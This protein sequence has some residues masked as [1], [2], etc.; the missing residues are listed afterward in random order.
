MTPGTQQTVTIAGDE[1]LAEF[2]QG[3]T[4]PAALAT[5]EQAG[6]RLLVQLPPGIG[7]TRWMERVILHVPPAGAFDLVVVLVPRW[8]ILGE[9]LD[10][11]PPDVRRVVLR[12]RPRKRCGDLD[13]EWLR[14]EQSG[15]GAL[16][17]EL[18]CASCPRRRSCGWP[19]QYGNSLRGVQLILA[20]QQHLI[21]NPSFVRFV[22]RQTKAA[23]ALVLVD[24]SDLLIRP[25]ERTIRRDDLDRFITV[26]ALL[27]GDAGDAS[28]ARARW[29]HMCK[30]AAAATTDDLR[31][32]GWRFP[33][34][35]TRWAVE[36]QRRGCDR[37]GEDFRFLGYD[38]HHFSRSDPSSRERLAGGDLRFAVLRSLGQNF[39]I[40]SGS[41]APGLARYRLDPDHT[42]P[43][44]AS[45]FAGH[46]FE[47]PGTRWYNLASMEGAARFFPGNAARI[48]DFFAALVA[49]NIRQG[50]RTLLVSRKKFI[51][52]CKAELRRR[53]GAMG[54][55]AVRVVTGDWRRHD[56]QDP[57]T[58][59]L[60]NFGVAGLNR[61]EHFEAAYC[62]NSYY[63]SADVV[64]D[65]TQEMEPSTARY[66][67]MIRSG[68]DPPRRRVQ[69]ALP[70]AR[71]PIT[72]FIAQAVLEQ[73]ESDVVV[74]A[75]G[76]VR[77]FT[78]P[79]EIITFHAGALP[80]ILYSWQFRRLAEARAF[81]GLQTAFQGGQASRR[82]RAR[83]LRAA[84]RTL[85]AIAQE[86]GVSLSTVQRDLRE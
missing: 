9:L 39:I 34:I 12:P 27:L 21:L 71:E 72:Q 11:L 81:F 1:A 73:K 25:A 70:D 68:G 16:G 60:I 50:K 31:G 86:L 2:R 53:L 56:L 3:L 63:V 65:A 46:V 40:F 55:G 36:V 84:G 14:L 82:A 47:H 62:L 74:Q 83:R 15:C 79:R 28:G 42:R 67:L 24:E 26:Q 78:R 17:R 48:L 19:E 59:P 6:G 44:L 64:S 33:P 37:F 7:K 38:L 58:I 13:A 41:I 20:T 4:G 32:G 85:R 77:P 45:P 75:V 8:D 18:L 52:L 80:G 43:P 51:P 22:T 49:R 30:L 10:R 29:L 57:R 35:F 69:L 61:F 54:V 66:P 5:L 76:R 23:N